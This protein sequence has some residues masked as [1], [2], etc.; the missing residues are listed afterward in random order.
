MKNYI[1]FMPLGGGQNV[2]ASCYYMQL[3]DSKILL[4][5]GVSYDN[6]LQINS[7][8]KRPFQEER[9]ERQI[10]ENTKE[11]DNPIRIVSGGLKS[12]VS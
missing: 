12:R 11:R 9:K 5:A 2:G 4:D 6:N 1:E 8:Y 7:K 10:T 3:G